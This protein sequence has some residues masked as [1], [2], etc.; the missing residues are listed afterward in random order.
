MTWLLNDFSR[1]HETDIF[2]HAVEGTSLGT[3]SRKNVGKILVLGPFESH[4]ELNFTSTA[5]K[6]SEVYYS[7]VFQLPKWRFRVT[8]FDESIEVSPVHAQYYQ[9]TMQQKEQLEARIKA[10]LADVA[11]SVADY[12]LVKHDERKYREFLD[13]FQKKD[14][15]S[16][17]SVFID[18][19]DVHTGDIAMRNIVQ[20]WPTLIADFLRLTDEDLD[21]D[22]VK[23]NLDISK[24]E[25]IVLV[26]KNKL[27]QEWKNLFMSEVQDRLTRITSLV[28]GRKKSID[29]YREWLK[30]YI[31]RF[32]LIKQA[33][34][35]PDERRSAMSDYIAAGG[36]ATSLSK[37]TLW[38]WKGLEVPGL[39]RPSPD[40]MP[41]NIVN[42][43]D[44]FVRKELIWNTKYGLVRKFPWLTEE[45]VGATAE[46]I[47]KNMM[48]AWVHYYGFMEIKF[49]RGDTRTADGQMIED[50]TFE[51]NAVLM[52]QN[53]LLVKMLE[54]KAKEQELERYI[55]EL[56]GIAPEPGPG[57][58][59]LIKPRKS[60]GSWLKFFKSGPYERD[61]ENRIT[62]FYLKEM[63]TGM[64]V[65]V[66]GFLKQK[67]GI[68]K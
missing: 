27:Y 59:P 60:S 56:L 3:W 20:R 22:K 50:G 33:F 2:K 8:K 37:V 61:F 1:D 57:K 9:L 49:I 67:F 24:A 40:A 38:T 10:G 25:A 6:T 29:E 34:E 64:Y 32:K 30:P 41:K 16:L 7:L 21:A 48:D 11:R 52:S 54:L 39:R 18:Q 65:P 43:Y 51:V 58:Q 4:T 31:T 35:N 46:D 15:H 62:K 63:A 66:V 68:G 19:V 17:R 47:R 45:W 55:S 13:Y 42:P 44:K 23:K 36:Q 5:G 26:T 12:E 14:E 53:A 28:Q